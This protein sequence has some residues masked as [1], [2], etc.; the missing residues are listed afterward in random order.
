MA[1]TFEMPYRPAYELT[2][3]SAW[4]AAAGLILWVMGRTAMPT[5][6]FKAAIG[7]ALGMAALRL[8]TGIQVYIQSRRLRSKDITF[9]EFEK[10][11]AFVE[12]TMKT[13]DPKVWLGWG[14]TWTKDASERTYEVIRRGPEKLIARKGDEADCYWVQAMPG[15]E[16]MVTVSLKA[17]EGHTLI[18]GTTGTGKT[19]L[20]DL[21]VTQAILRGD[22]VFIFDPK[23]DDDLKERA[24]LACAASGDPS[25][26]MLFDPAKPQESWCI[27]PL[28]NYN[29]PTE[30]ASRVAELVPSE[31]GGD[32]FKSFGWKALND[33]VQGLVITGKRPNLVN[34]RRYIQG[35]IGELLN[36]ALKAH[37]TKHS[38]NW[39]AD[40]AE[41]FR[42]IG[43]AVKGGEVAAMI[44]FYRDVIEA[45]APSSELEGI[46]SN[47]EHNRE[48]MM[49]LIASLHPLLAMLTAGE[50]SALLSP[51]AEDA[52]NSNRVT[53]SAAIIRN[54][55]CMYFDLDTLSDGIVGSAIG[56]MYLSDLTAVAGDRYNFGVGS[57]PVSIFIDE[58][59]ELINAPSV[60]L[61]NKGRGANMRLTV[62]TQTI[63][64]FVV[65]MG[66][67]AAANK[68]IGNLNNIITL[69]VIDDSTVEQITKTLPE[70]PIRSVT[71][72]LR[73]GNDSTDP[74]GF[75][76]GYSEDLSE[77]FMP[78]IPRHLLTQL[79]N[80]HYLAR[81]TD[82]RYV[83]GRLPILKAPVDHQNVEKT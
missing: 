18:T 13:D 47:F 22:A 80:F 72:S 62:A 49:K 53:D 69:R 54:G 70:F 34:I 1:N 11:K 58:A 39:E 24:R 7:V 14:G 4:L 12:K 36:D 30:L 51:T 65:R 38:P 42:S 64:D 44:K 68:A 71:R 78:M 5:Y 52:L 8:F 43:K 6:P 15:P 32:V 35:D 45:K 55:G 76:G 27:D 10:V 74:T 61:A 16:Q 79:P 9:L 77:E 56:S 33:V 23:G 46:I 28:K 41:Y 83:K 48:H 31:G 26:F 57:R 67:E 37:F 2:A 21:L 81:F 50:L 25:R 19:R 40:A 82:G 73:S 29:R 60:Q 20:L 63:P 75:Q 66:S 3:G 17:L 59:A